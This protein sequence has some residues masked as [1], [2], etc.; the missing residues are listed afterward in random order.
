M[1]GWKVTVEHNCYSKLYCCEL[2]RLWV[3]ALCLGNLTCRS[4]LEQ[5]QLAPRGACANEEVLGEEETLAFALLT[6]GERAQPGLAQLPLL[7]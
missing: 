7:R 1:H 6:Q 3:L 2:S 5:V 4:H